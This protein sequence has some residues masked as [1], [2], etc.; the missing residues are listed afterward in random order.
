[1]DGLAFQGARR[2][3]DGT[4]RVPVP[5]V[6]LFSGPGGLAEGFASVRDS[7]NRRRF[8]VALSIEV[9]PAAFRTLRLRAFVRKFSA[10]LPD[11]YYEYLNGSESVEPDWAA[12]YPRQWREASDETRCL[13]LG[14]PEATSFLCKRVR[15]IW[16]VHKGRTVLLG[17]PPCQSYSLVGRARNAGKPG[18]DADTDE[19]QS[20]YLEYA[21]ALRLLRPAVAVMENVRGMLSAGHNGEPVFPGVMNALGNA[22]GKGQYRLFA[23][24]SDTVGRSWNEGLEPEEFLVRA[25]AHGVPQ[26]RHRVFVICIRRDVAQALPEKFLP[27]LEPIETVV[28]VD[29]VIGNMPV[30]RSRLSRSDDGPTWQRAVRE[31]HALV[32][33]HRPTMAGKDDRQFLRALSQAVKSTRGTALPFGGETGGTDFSESCPVDLRGWLFDARISRLPNNETRGHIPEDLSRYLYAAAFASTIG[34]SPRAADFPEVLAPEHANWNTGKFTDRFRVQL[35]DRPS[36]TI[37]SHISKDGHYFIHPDPRQCRSLTVRE[38]ARLQTFPDNYLFLGGRTQQYVQV[39]NAVPPYLARQIAEQVA[40][41]LQHQDRIAA[42][43]SRQVRRAGS[44]SKGN[45]VAGATRGRVR[46]PGRS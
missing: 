5:T 17:G 43:T 35:A 28:S 20:L 11:E 37:T 36:T 44:V 15:E 13:E 18:Y 8:R 27:K 6:D 39:G 24:T 2:G 41:I 45:S 4:V 21:A 38:A 46:S 26:A 19:R 40:G 10:D 9:D 1:M 25:E 31:A 16:K 22:G 34:R 32:K 42:R 3:S 14:A 29:D 23:L 33:R 12:L 7:A 30:L